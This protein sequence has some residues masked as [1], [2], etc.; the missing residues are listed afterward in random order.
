MRDA[1]EALHVCAAVQRVDEGDDRVLALSQRD[2]VEAGT[3]RRERLRRRMHAASD[4]ER[5]VARRRT[6]GLEL[7]R[8]LRKVW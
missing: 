7:L 4:V 2:Q 8:G 3:Q 5:G 1:G 6:H